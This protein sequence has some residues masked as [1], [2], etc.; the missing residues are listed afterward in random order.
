MSQSQLFSG[1]QLKRLE[2][3]KP[4]KL[5]EKKTWQPWDVFPFGGFKGVRMDIV[6]EVSPSTLT[7]W[8]QKYKVQFSPELVNLIHQ[9]LYLAK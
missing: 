2:V 5:A 4:R 9:H 6:A 3:K 7:W 1:R 8:Q